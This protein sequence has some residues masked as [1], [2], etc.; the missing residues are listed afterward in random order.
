MKMGEVEKIA[1]RAR[2]AAR[3]VQALS[4]EV[5]NGA[6]AVLHDRMVADREML[7][8]ANELDKEA[9]R[10]ALSEGA[11]ESSLFKRLDLSGKKFDGALEGIKSVERL[12]DPVGAV[13]LARRMDDGLDLFRVACPIGVIAVIF[14][15]RPEAAVQIACLAIKSGNAVILKGGKEGEHSNAAIVS[16][17]R[18][19]LNQVGFPMDAVQLVATREQVREL[20][21]QDAYVDLIIPRGSNS[22]VSYITNNTRIPVMGHADGICSVYIGASADE[23]K[24]VEISVD[25]KAQY[26]AVC[27]AAETLL[28]DRA[29]LHLL[30][31][32]G[33]AMA[34]AGVQLRAD[35][36]AKSILDTVGNSL[37]VIEATPEDF[38]TEFLEL[39]MAVKVVQC[40]NEAVAHIN[41]HGSGHTDCIV[42]EDSVTA[43]LFM[44]GVDSAGTFHNA[45]TRFADGFRMGF[46]AEVGVST[47]RTHARG[48][49]GLEGLMIYKY[50]LLGTGQT[51][52]P[53]ADGS[54]SFLHETI[55]PRELR[56][57]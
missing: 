14:E 50:K 48:P 39:K 18:A 9:A 25:S 33:R 41:L 46:G 54:R 32:I 24:A 31:S 17:I 30:P 52:A 8:A 12:P 11:M 40:V 35:S 10:T 6:L 51:V 20:L 23:K 44:A 1:K 29:A 49:V 16:T 37:D 56:G 34:A 47:H 5:R 13:S 7:L 19:A 43:S 28:I 3:A 42:T 26:P 38:D 45:S 4:T 53:Y 55:D 21:D 36:E 57:R 2:V 22:L 15:A 27:N